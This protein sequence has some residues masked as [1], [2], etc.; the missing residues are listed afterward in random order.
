MFTVSGLISNEEKEGISSENIIVGGFSQGG[1]VALY[2]ALTSPKKLGGIVGLSTW[3]PLHKQFP[4]VSR[5]TSSST[6]DQMYMQ[7]S[8]NLLVDICLLS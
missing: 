3:L 7:H 8:N 6:T 2:T 4:Q 1:A 5:N